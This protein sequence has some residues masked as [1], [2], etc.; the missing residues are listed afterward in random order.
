MS[1][2]IFCNINASQEKQNIYLVGED[3]SL[4]HLDAVAPDDVGHTVVR[5]ALENKAEDVLLG[6]SSEAYLER[7]VDDIYTINAL[8]YTNNNIKVHILGE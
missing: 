7:F 2:K 1:V 4:R 5:F 8:M 3:G 6:G